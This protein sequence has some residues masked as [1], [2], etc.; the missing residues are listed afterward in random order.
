MT[1]W[2]VWN[3]QFRIDSLEWTVWNRQFRMGVLSRDRRFDAAASGGF[4]DGFSR[5]SST[6]CSQF[7]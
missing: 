7:I 1:G 5:L 4:K 3:G 6:L 2:T